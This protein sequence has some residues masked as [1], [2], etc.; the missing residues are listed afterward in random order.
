MISAMGRAVVSSKEVASL[1][2][3]TEPKND[4]AREFYESFQ[5][6]RLNESQL[7]LTMKEASDQ[8]STL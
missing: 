2:I 8:L 4:R 1:A 5:F 3:T 7:D 6:Q